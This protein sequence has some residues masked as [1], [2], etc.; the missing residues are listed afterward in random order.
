MDGACS[1][2]GHVRI[3]KE[4]CRV[5]LLGAHISGLTPL[6]GCPGVPPPCEVSAQAAGSASTSSPPTSA[7][8]LRSEVVAIRRPASAVAL[9]SSSPE[10]ASLPLEKMF[11]SP[12]QIAAFSISTSELLTLAD[13]G[14]LRVGNGANTAKTQARRSSGGVCILE[15]RLH[16]LICCISFMLLAF[17]TGAVM[18]WTVL[19]VSCS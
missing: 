17:G 15:I 10:M 1:P 9:G 3:S 12:V 5:A 19:A 2:R 6:A 8:T 13:M 11:D 18:R 14:K 7:G 16:V 4:F